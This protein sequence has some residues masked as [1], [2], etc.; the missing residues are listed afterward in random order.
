MIKIKKKS[1]DNRPWSF[2][3]SPFSPGLRLEWSQF[4]IQDWIKKFKKNGE[5]CQKN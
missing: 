1:K 2:V 5:L 4:I 3:S